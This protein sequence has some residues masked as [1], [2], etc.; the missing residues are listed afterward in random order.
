MRTHFDH[1]L[2]TAA[3]TFNVKIRSADEYR[4]FL[5]KID[6]FDFEAWARHCDAERSDAD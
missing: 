6:A 4:L 2:E 5:E 3:L 1:T